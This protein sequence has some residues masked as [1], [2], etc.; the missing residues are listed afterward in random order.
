VTDHKRRL[1][2]AELAET[3]ALL[4]TLWTQRVEIAEALPAADREMAHRL[5]QRDA[6]LLEQE[7]GPTWR[8]VELQ[9][10]LSVTG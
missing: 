1:L 5:R 8:S 6:L 10:Q 3:R 4:E 9:F 7:V 2:L